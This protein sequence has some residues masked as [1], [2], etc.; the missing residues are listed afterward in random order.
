MSDTATALLV[1]S[2]PTVYG[3][4][5]TLDL[6][7]AAFVERTPTVLSHSGYRLWNII[8]SVNGGCGVVTPATSEFLSDGSEPVYSFLP[9]VGYTAA[10]VR[11]WPIDSALEVLAR[12]NYVL[13][14]RAHVDV[15]EWEDSSDP[16][17]TRVTSV[18]GTTLPTGADAAFYSGTTAGGASLETD[19]QDLPEG[20]EAGD[21]LS[22]H[23]EVFVAGIEQDD[24]WLELS[25]Y[26]PTGFTYSAITDEEVLL[27]LGG[28]VRF[29]GFAEIPESE[30]QFT[31][32]A[33]CN[34]LVEGGADSAGVYLTKVMVEVGE[35]PG[36]YADGDSEGW[37][38]LG[39]DHASVSTLS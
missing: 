2:T 27:P 34:A 18:P 16:G 37:E 5:G 31:V 17:A 19:V 4:S 15:A 35:T 7:E 38:W 10:C 21:F 13:N 24:A 12:S 28:F 39:T 26:W 11:Y 6:A 8:P 30:T 14:P 25:V 3:A 22:L 23:C 33:T 1:A 9:Q 20:L 29:S 36:L 32:Y